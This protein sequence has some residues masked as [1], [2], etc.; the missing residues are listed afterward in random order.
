MSLHPC[1]APQPLRPPHPALLYLRRLQRELL[2]LFM[3]MPEDLQW[4][5]LSSPSRRELLLSLQLSVEQRDKLGAMCGQLQA[6][7]FKQ[8]PTSS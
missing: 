1:P 2:T 7:G 6:T 8:Q 5:C 3:G 4:T